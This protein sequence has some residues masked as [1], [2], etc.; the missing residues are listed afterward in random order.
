M[1]SPTSAANAYG[2]LA[3]LIP[4][5]GMEKAAGSAAGAIAGGDKS[6]SSMLKVPIRAAIR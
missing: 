1:T 5:A 3:K 6:F 2:S 4:G